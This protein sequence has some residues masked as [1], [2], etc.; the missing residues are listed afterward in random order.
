MDR[1]LTNIWAASAELEMLQVQ[2]DQAHEALVLALCTAM[3]AQIPPE[4]VAAAAN[5]DL[6]E[7]FDTLRRPRIAPSPGNRDAVR[8]L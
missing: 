2:I 1:N 5:M 3:A 6:P 7:L 8:D 4:E